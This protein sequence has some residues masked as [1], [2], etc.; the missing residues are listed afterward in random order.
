MSSQPPYANTTGYGDNEYGGST[1]EGQSIPFVSATPLATGNMKANIV[2]I[3]ATAL[4]TISYIISCVTSY[5]IKIDDW[6][7]HHGTI[8]PTPHI[9]SMIQVIVQ[10]LIVLISITMVNVI[11]L[12]KYQLPSNG[13]VPWSSLHVPYYPYASLTSPSLMSHSGCILVNRYLWVRIICSISLVANSRITNRNIPSLLIIFSV[14]PS[15][16]LFAIWEH[17]MSDSKHS[18][19][20][21]TF[22]NSF[23]GRAINQFINGSLV[24]LDE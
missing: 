18:F 13:C 10:P 15:I 19:G 24:G 23:L 14:L 5:W 6:R 17:Q 16:E 11:T 1:G 7:F 22:T 9:I 20:C 2:Y 3:S 8:S 4:L 12:L 21:K